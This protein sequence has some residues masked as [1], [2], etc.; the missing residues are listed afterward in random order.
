MD[1]NKRPD[2]FTG[3]QEE[4]E[5]HLSSQ[6]KTF[7]QRPFVYHSYIKDSQNVQK[8]NHFIKCIK[9]GRLPDD[10]TLSWISCNFENYIKGTSLSLDSAFGLRS[11]PKKGNSA[12]QY[13]KEIERNELLNTMASILV[14]DKKISKIKVA[15]MA[16]NEQ[17]NTEIEP[18][19]L[20]RYFRDWSTR[21]HALDRYK[22][23]ARR[24]ADK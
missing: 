8:I 19:T 11:K 14:E 17:N 21:E 13:K 5:T 24:K 1:T 23:R 22:T 3:S 18:E 4:W 10:E 2:W 9:N 12:E 7:V 6:Q 20:A 15:E 16:L